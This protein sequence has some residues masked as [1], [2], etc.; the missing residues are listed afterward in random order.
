MKKALIFFIIAVFA[1]S[2]VFAMDLSLGVM[3]NFL[4]TSI[5]ADLEFNHFGFEESFGFPL[6]WGGA[7]LINAISDGKD[8]DIGDIGAMSLLPGFMVNGY[9]KA[10]NTK[11][12]SLRLGLQADVIGI[13]DGDI[14][15]VLGLWGAS[16]GLNFK[17]SERF[18]AN[19]TGTIPAEFPLSYISDDAEKF[20][21]F[22]SDVY[23]LDS[24]DNIFAT[25][26]GIFAQ[27]ADGIIS[28]SARVSFKWNI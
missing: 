17:L 26:A 28:E 4:N 9:W 22:I 6:I 12:F 7:S 16:I 21:Y 27:H 19:I 23:G 20:G 24:V 15:T 3:Q 2:S 14:S 25:L 10:I 11:H 18:S 13:S 8:V 1:G 5:I